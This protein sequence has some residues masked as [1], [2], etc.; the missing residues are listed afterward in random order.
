MGVVR[1]TSVFGDDSDSDSG[2]A[3]P[4]GLKTALKRQVFHFFV[5]VIIYV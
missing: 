2:S 5:A 3:K 1:P 4:T